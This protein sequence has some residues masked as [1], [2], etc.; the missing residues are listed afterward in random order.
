MGAG[1]H[2]GTLGCW[3]WVGTGGYVGSAG[4]VGMRGGTVGARVGT[5]EPWGI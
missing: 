5:G 2:G 4:V 1:G 3:A